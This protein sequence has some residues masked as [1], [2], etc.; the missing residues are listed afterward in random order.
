MRILTFA[1]LLA[2]SARPLLACDLC[3]IYAASEAQGGGKGFFGGVAEQ[4][5][6]F[7]TVQ[8]DG[9]ELANDADQY[10][11]SSVAQLFAGYNFNRRFGVQFN[12]PI[13]Y[14]SFQRP[15]GAVIDR[16]TESGIGDVSLIGNFI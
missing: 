5:T 15:R 11:E 9:Q 3:S 14:R 4:F 6:H 8:E 12:A 1:V 2:A 10:S 16:G 7:G 13:I